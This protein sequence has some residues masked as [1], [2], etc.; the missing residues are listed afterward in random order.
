MITIYDIAKKTGYSPATVSKALNNYSDIGAKTKLYILKS[1]KE[2]GYTPNYNAKALITKKSW[3]IGVLYSDVQAMG[4]EHPLFGGIIEGFKNRVEEEGYEIMF[5]SRKLG[6]RPM[7]YLEHCRHRGVDGV[8]LTVVEEDDEDVIELIN[9]GLKCVSADFV[10]PNLASVISDNQKGAQE[11]MNYI[12]SLGHRRIAHL[13][14]PISHI[15][16]RERLEAYKSALKEA[17]IAYDPSLV[18]MGKRYDNISGYLSMQELLSKNKEIPTAIFA[19]CDSIAYGA[20]LAAREDGFRVPE[21][22]SFVGFDDYD[23]S[24]YFNPSLTTIKQFKRELGKTAADTLLSIIKGEE[25]LSKDI[26]VKVELKI[27]ASC[28]PVNLK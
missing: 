27:R 3:I 19:A 8:F 1:A 21:D 22:I 23:T 9:S 28:V 4:L 18:V 26:R 17:E 2:M 7:S 6:G 5:I 20:I 10:N 24:A 12:L 16:A 14:G 13:G 11:G 15:A 25:I